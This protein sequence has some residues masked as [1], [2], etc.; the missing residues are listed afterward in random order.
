MKNLSRKNKNADNIDLLVGYDEFQD[1]IKEIR[2]FLEIPINGFAK[3]EAIKN[4]TESTSKKTEDISNSKKFRDQEKEIR[5]QLDSKKATPKQ[6][7]QEFKKIG[8][9]LP[10]NYLTNSIKNLIETFHLP[11]HYDYFLRNYIIS[12]TIR[13]PVNG[14]TITP[15]KDK[16]NVQ[17]NVHMRLTDQDLREI[18]KEVN[19]YFGKDLPHAQKIDDLSKKLDVENMYKNKVVLEEVTRETYKIDDGDIAE[20]VY[21]DRSKKNSVRSTVQNLKSMRK[22]RFSND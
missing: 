20:T 15:S 1:A 13:Y 8:N 6:A 17:V 7:E 3:S 12:N 2:E 4:W 5:K 16:K 10:W 18:K 21:R 14:F 11:E 22:R 19:Q 9:D